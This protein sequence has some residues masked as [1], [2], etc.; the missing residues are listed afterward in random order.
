MDDSERATAKEEILREEALSYRK[1]PRTQDVIA[2]SGG[3]MG[4]VMTLKYCDTCG[5][6]RPPHG[7]PL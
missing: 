1:P 5:I 4:G 2:P 7:K 6:I 3:L